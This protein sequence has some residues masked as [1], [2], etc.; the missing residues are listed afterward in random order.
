MPLGTP[1]LGVAGTGDVLTGVIAA[2]LA[3]VE[4]TF[5]AACAAVVLHAK[6]GELAAPIGSGLL[7]HEVADRL[8]RAL[9]LARRG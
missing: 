9:E 6:A 8:P 7:A 2:A 5:E 3:S 4:T 1:A